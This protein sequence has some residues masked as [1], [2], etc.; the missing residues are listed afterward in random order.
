MGALALAALFLLPRLSR[1][2]PAG[3]VVL[4]GAIALSS[5]LDLEGGA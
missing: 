4:F 1:R 2:L 5:A 3:L